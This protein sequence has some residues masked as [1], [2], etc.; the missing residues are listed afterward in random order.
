MWYSVKLIGNGYKLSNNKLLVVNSKT[1]FYEQ[2][3]TKFCK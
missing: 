2:F 1:M 3:V